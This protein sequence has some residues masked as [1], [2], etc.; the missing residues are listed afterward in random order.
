MKRIQ[1]RKSLREQIALVLFATCLLL[2]VK[3]EGVLY[4]SETPMKA[5]SGR[6]GGEGGHAEHRASAMRSY[7][8]SSEDLSKDSEVLVFRPDGS[9]GEA[10]MHIC[11]EGLMLTVDTRPMDASSDGNFLVYVL[12]RHVEDETLVVRVAK[13]NLLN[14]SCRWGHEYK[15]NADRLRPKFREEVPLDLVA[16]PL[17]D[18]NFHSRTMSGDVMDI[19]AL[20]YGKPL[21]GANI[22][23][24]TQGG[25]TKTFQSDANGNA[26]VQLIRDYYPAAWSN[27]SRD[28]KGTFQ[29]MAEVEF[30]ETGILGEQPYRKVRVTTSLPWKYASSKR[31]YQSYA[32]GLSLGATFMIV[33][34]LG[35]FI[36]RERRRK[37]YRDIQFDEHR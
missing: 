13:L 22:S 23:L 5:A 21:E 12:D 27:F 19:Q 6:G 8:L 18:G 16:S 35:V 25:W 37:S 31:E 3:G 36:Y 11:G 1:P 4:I 14:H 24:R 34:G 2:P 30:E 9:R 17:W 10:S 26:S 32:Y 33:S 29:I 15:F 7:Y 20:R 28:K